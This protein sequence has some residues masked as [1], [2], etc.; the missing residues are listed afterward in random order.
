VIHDATVAG[1][2]CVDV[3]IRKQK[4]ATFSGGEGW[5]AGNDEGNQYMHSD[6]PFAMAVSMTTATAIG[7]TD[8]FGCEQV[9]RTS[10]VEPLAQAW[11][12][13]VASLTLA[14]TGCSATWAMTTPDGELPGVVGLLPC[15]DTTV[16]G[17]VAGEN[18]Q[19]WSC[20]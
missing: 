9:L 8:E 10:L 18:T 14:E 12:F 19:L 7:M 16:G 6:G 20:P 3:E 15:G 17:V 5:T 1:A 11:H 2:T 13:E 4:V